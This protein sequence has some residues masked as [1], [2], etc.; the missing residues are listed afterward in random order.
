VLVLRYY[1]DLGEA[2]M[3][4]RLDVPAGT[5]KSRLHTAR[6]HLRALLPSWLTPPGVGEENDN[7]HVSYL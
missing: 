4:A 5:V 2:E 7:K 3:S 6:K 1:L